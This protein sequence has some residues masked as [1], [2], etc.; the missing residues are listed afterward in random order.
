MIPRIIH[1]TSKVREIPSTWSAYQQRV[2]ALHDGW[3]YHHWTDQENRELVQR[4][5]PRWLPLYDSLA[6]PI[7]KADMIRYVYMLVSGGL[8]LDFDF[9]FI[10]TFDLLDRSLVVP[11]QSDDDR[12]LGLGNAVLASEPGHPFWEAVLEEL[13]HRVHQL[14]RKPLEDE[15]VETTGPGL[16]TA[17]Y[18][19]NP[20]RYPD[21]YSGRREQFNPS[22][23]N[24][25]ERA[26]LFR[27]GRTYGIHH[28]D[29]T[30]R[31]KTLTQRAARKLA[32]MASRRRKK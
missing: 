32:T 19:R 25:E 31:A 29:G 23:F 6:L 13:A 5:V 10:K 2:R 30:W 4:S 17:V 22:V 3:E 8:Y 9:E 21:L 27:S 16:L 24:E 1:Q 15:I 26:A 20:G 18:L 28:T 7:M 12:P 11:R 14:G